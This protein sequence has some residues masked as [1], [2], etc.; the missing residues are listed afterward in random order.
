MNNH[1]IICKNNI[2]IIFLILCVI[3]I[4]I[5]LNKKVK[6]NIDFS[7]IGFEYNFCININYFFDI[8]TLY[9]EDLLK[10]KEQFQKSKYAQKLKKLKNLKNQKEKRNFILKALSI[11][12]T[13]LEKL[14]LDKINIDRINLKMNLGLQDVFVTSMAI[15]FLSSV[16]AILMQKYLSKSTKQFSVKPVYN[17]FFFSLKSATYV[18][19]KL[20]DLISIVFK[21]WKAQNKSIKK[22]KILII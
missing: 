15:P 13:N 2:M 4:L 18:S 19:V 9:K 10:Y 6:F 12:K 8:I 3:I 1:G 14:R 17:K 22:E 7:V 16:I 20:K 11:E 5:L 21:I